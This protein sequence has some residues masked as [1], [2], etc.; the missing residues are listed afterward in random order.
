MARSRLDLRRD[1]RCGKLRGT[2]PRAYG[3]R[4]E[5]DPSH[6]YFEDDTGLLALASCVAATCHSAAARYQKA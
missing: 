2:A 5:S 3:G 6:L 1:G 4:Y